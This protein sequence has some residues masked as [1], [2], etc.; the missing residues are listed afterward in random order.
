VSRGRPF[1]FQQATPV[2]GAQNKHK[3]N[4][5]H[6]FTLE[7]VKVSIFRF[8]MQND[9]IWA[10]NQIAKKVVRTAEKKPK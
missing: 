1:N 4:E 6:K 8:K 2:N 9:P 10:Y 3:K 7:V 5:C